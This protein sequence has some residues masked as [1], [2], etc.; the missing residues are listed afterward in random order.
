[1]T[2]MSNIRRVQ[3]IFPEL[4]PRLLEEMLKHG[5]FLQIPAGEMLMDHSLPIPYIPLV[6]EGLI[7][8]IRD[9]DEHELLLYFLEPGETCASSLICA[10]DA[11][12]SRIRATAVEHSILLTLPIQ[13]MDEWIRE[14]PSWY[15][16]ILRSWQQKFDELLDT[17]DSIAFSHMDSRIERHLLQIVRI[18]KVPVIQITHQQL[19]LELG[20]R[21]EVVSR[22]LK[23][24][25][26]D[27]KIRLGRN[28]IEWLEPSDI[29]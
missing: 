2:E 20:T 10:A 24:M 28:L 27:G 29:H 19:A 4:E 26:N 14:F 16:F 1:M 21:R 23:A 3:S 18:Q 12:K 8:V 6:I 25:E 13:K 7:K 11:R 17:V 15:K 5:R 22:L 9:N